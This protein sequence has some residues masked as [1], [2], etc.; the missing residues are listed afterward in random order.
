MKRDPKIIEKLKGY[1]PEFDR[2][3]SRP[4]PSFIIPIDD[5][6]PV[7]GNAASFMRDDDYVIGFTMGKVARAY[8]LWIIDYYHVVNDR[9]EGTPVVVFS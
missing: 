3:S 5:P 1:L 7:T 2:F 6:V 9:L 4:M 8:P